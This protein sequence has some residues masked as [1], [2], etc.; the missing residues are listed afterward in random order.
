MTKKRNKR[1]ARK[2]ACKIN[3]DA[4]KDSMKACRRNY[5][6]GLAKQFAEQST[7]NS[8]VS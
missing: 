8:G 7:G 6:E 2:Q 5:G 4:T 1:F 3:S